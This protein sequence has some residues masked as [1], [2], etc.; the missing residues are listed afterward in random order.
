[1]DTVFCPIDAYFAGEI[2]AL[3]QPPPSAQAQ[4]ISLSLSGT[5]LCIYLAE[6][7]FQFFPFCKTQE[8]FDQLITTR[9]CTGLKVKQ[10]GAHGK[11]M[12]SHISVSC[13]LLC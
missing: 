7:G 2:S 5:E 10:N 8:Y 3:L 11:G 13:K 12:F 1:M 6:G 4:A 9:G